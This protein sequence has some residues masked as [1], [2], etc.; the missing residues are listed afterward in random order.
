MKKRPLL[1]EAAAL[2]QMPSPCRR[3]V[4]SLCLPGSG[5]VKLTAGGVAIALLAIF[6]PTAA[7][8][9]L[10]YIRTAQGRTIDLTAMCSG[11][12]I[13]PSPL[14]SP[15]TQPAATGVTAAW[16]GL[17][18]GQ[19]GGDLLRRS[20][21]TGG[22][23]PEESL[24]SYCNALAAGRTPQQIQQADAQAIVQS[25]ISG[26]ALEAARTNIAAIAILARTRC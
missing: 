5:L 16:L 23:N 17:I 22:I 13:P 9:P 19:P 2:Y 8:E 6:A 7:A 25:G 24:A 10:C 12:R 3:Q 21:G 26:L 14:P 4:T 1:L 11:D 18:Q 20:W 15:A